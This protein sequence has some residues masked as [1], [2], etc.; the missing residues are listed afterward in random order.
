MAELL[1]LIIGIL[2]LSGLFSGAEAS[3]ISL[4]K[5]EIEGFVQEKRWGANILARVH[6][7]L[8]RA[9]NTIVVLNNIVNIAGSILVGSMTIRLFGDA[10]LAVVTTSLTFGVIIFSEIL[11]KSLGMH[12]SH[13][14]AIPVAIVVY[15]LM[16]PLFPLIWLLEQ[17]T[18]IFKKGERKIGTEQQIRSLVNLG[19]RSG[20]IENDEGQ[21]VHRAFILNDKTAHDIMTPLKDVISVTRGETIDE[22]AKKVFRENHSRFPVFG[23]SIHDVEG[24]VMGYDILQAV[25]EGNKNDHIGTIVQ[26]GLIVSEDRQCDELLVLFRD[27]RQHQAVVQENGKTVGIVTLEDVLEELVGEIEDELDARD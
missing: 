4:S 9:V 27:K 25:T 19:R 17:F 10:I 3:L 7:K 2:V 14:L 1:I 21:L 5:P 11:P 18:Q 6:K 16:M 15:Y 20:H 8:E 13:R 22:A 23:N 12:Y 24:V 26:P